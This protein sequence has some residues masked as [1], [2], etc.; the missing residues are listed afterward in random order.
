LGLPTILSE[1]A[2]ADRRA[3]APLG[4]PIVTGSGDRSPDASGSSSAERREQRDIT[5]DPGTKAP[6]SQSVLPWYA[7]SNRCAPLGIPS[8]P[9]HAA[10][11]SCLRPIARP[12][13]SPTW[14]PEDTTSALEA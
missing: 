8:A 2:G 6:S 10:H 3:V 14:L 9:G 4:L 1:P 5:D 7:D 12:R 11:G 13:P